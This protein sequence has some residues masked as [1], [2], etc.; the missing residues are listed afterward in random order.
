VEP[1]ISVVHEETD[2]ETAVLEVAREPNGGLVVMPDTFTFL[3]RTLIIALA[4]KQRVPAIYPYPHLCRDGG[5]V[6]YGPSW[7]HW[8]A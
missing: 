3:H 2:L 7:Q 8:V 5:L 4:D 6:S 1:I